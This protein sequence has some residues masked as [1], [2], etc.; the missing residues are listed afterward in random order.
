MAEGVSVDDWAA[1]AA[2]D[3]TSAAARNAA[4]SDPEPAGFIRRG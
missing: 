1:A 4:G 3:S 2:A